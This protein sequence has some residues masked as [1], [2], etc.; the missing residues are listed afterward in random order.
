MYCRFETGMPVEH[1][2]FALTCVAMRSGLALRGV[3]RDG[4]VGPERLATAA[5]PRHAT[6]YTG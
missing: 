5:R 4:Q 3:R 2:E 1:A 6:S